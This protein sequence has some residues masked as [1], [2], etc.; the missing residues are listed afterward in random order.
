[1][2]NQSCDIKMQSMCHHK[3][4]RRQGWAQISKVTRMTGCRLI[5]TLSSRRIVERSWGWNCN[6]LRRLKK[7]YN[8]LLVVNVSR[9]ALLT[10]TSILV[11][12]S[13]TMEPCDLWCCYWLFENVCFYPRLRASW[14]SECQMHTRWV[15]DWSQIILQHMSEPYYPKYESMYA[16]LQLIGGH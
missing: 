3:L 4:V 5:E 10:D 14:K 11:G 2:W 7:P 8:C 15:S 1:M 6:V 16:D 12:M 13:I 9:L